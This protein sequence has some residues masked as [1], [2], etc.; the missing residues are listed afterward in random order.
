M[1]SNWYLQTPKY[2]SGDENKVVSDLAPS[3]FD[4]LLAISPEAYDVKINNVNGRIIVQSQ[5]VKNDVKNVRAKIGSVKI[6]DI[7]TH[8]QLSWLI[9][10]YMDDNTMHSFGEMEMCSSNFVINNAPTKVKVGNDPSGKPIYNTIAGMTKTY[11]CV[12]NNKLLRAN[13]LDSELNLPK[14]MIIAK[15][16]YD[17][18]NPNIDY[19]YNIVDVDLSDT[20]E[21]NGIRY[22]VIQ[23]LASRVQ[24]GQG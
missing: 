19:E 6:G 15:M 10:T 1:P 5:N 9:T 13:A 4:E 20:F 12:V 24:Q 17:S 11:P 16:S 8:K 18:L 3:A 14:G 2:F 7:I 21:S 23:V 22:G